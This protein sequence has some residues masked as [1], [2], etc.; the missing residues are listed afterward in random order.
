MRTLV[1]SD[2]HLGIRSRRDVLRR[3][4]PLDALVQALDG[5]DRL[6][7]LGD[8][9]DLGGHARRRAMAVAE[10]VMRALGQRVGP[11]GESCWSRAITTEP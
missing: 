4:A 7:L 8:V 5:V 3:A 2:L 10:P 1:V 11:A 9:V 6:V